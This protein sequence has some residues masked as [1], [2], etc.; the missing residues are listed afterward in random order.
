MPV[1]F[2]PWQVPPESYERKGETVHQCR[3]QRRDVVRGSAPSRQ[4]LEGH[5]RP[6]DPEEQRK[7][8][9]RIRE[10]DSTLF[11]D[12]DRDRGFAVSGLYTVGE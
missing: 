2:Q 3:D 4:D 10:H 7:L 5:R 11:H 12:P 9:L 6:S 8:V 1:C